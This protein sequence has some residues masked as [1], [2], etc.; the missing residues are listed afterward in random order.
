MYSMSNNIEIYEG[1]ISFARRIIKYDLGWVQR[2]LFDHKDFLYTSPFMEKWTRFGNIK[3]EEKPPGHLQ[4]M[5]HNS[6]FFSSHV[7][8]KKC[9]GG[10]W[11][12]VHFY[13][14]I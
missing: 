9:V 5:V 6:P 10:D 2:V 7:I 14:V 13:N 3:C 1:M 4:N 11:V 8:R 12:I